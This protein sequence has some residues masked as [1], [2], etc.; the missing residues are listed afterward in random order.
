M[1]SQKQR[2]NMNPK[3]FKMN[4]YDVYTV[5]DVPEKKKM[6]SVLYVLIGNKPSTKQKQKLMYK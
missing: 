6:K 2:H 5:Y 4:S 3:Q 1:A